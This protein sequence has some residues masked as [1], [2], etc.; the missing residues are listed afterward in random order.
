MD[1]KNILVLGAIE[2]FCD[3]V[4]DLDDMGY[5]AVCCD[6]YEHAAAKKISK[7][8][9][10]VSTTDVDKVVEIGKKHN[11]VGVIMAFSD[12]NLKPAFEVCRMLGLP[13]Y[14]SEEVI[15][16]LTDKINMKDHFKKN[17][18]PV[19][20]YKILDAS[21]DDSELDGLHFP[22]ILKPIDGYG[23]KGI[24]KCQNI[25]DIRENL[26]KCLE[27][28]QKYNDRFLVEEFYDADEISVSGWVKGGKFYLTST[29]D[30]GRN[31]E[32]SVILSYVAFP[33][34]YEKKYK[35]QLIDVI[36]KLTESLAIVEG[37][38]TVQFF[39][40]P[41]GLKVSEYL[42]RLAGGSPYLYSVEQGGPNTAKMLIDYQTGVEIDYQNLH[43]YNCD[44][45]ERYYDI[46][47]FA[48]KEGRIH[49]EKSKEE[50]LRIYGIEKIL[51]Y[52]DDNE[53]LY[54]VSKKGRLVMRLFYK[55]KADDSR[56]YEEI[57]D[58][59]RDQIVLRD[60]HGENITI[61]RCPKKNYGIAKW[62]I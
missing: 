37:P 4:H 32:S 5:N 56:S 16:I 47:V 3:I 44:Y 58:D 48:S 23:S 62:E 57:V 14:Y 49:Y 46:L 24:Y 36:Q 60:D 61:I 35:V 27:S 45:N 19:I 52:H 30:V 31:F 12:R 6:F 7:Y 41:N 55:H 21:F 1:K 34:Q 10:L 51:M 8:S 17:G 25:A 2:S 39:V 20:P 42:F 11:V 22:V 13:V 40:G 29:Y 59:L 54:D 53:Y 9:Y 50:L 38:V 43:T 28:S 33:S 26:N 18:F 15:D